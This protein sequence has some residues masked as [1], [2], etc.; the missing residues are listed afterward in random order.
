MNDPEDEDSINALSYETSD[1]EGYESD[2]YEIDEER[3]IADQEMIDTEPE[4]SMCF[5]S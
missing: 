3:Y 2:G 5:R 1:I 4:G